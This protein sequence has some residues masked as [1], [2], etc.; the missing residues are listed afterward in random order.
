MSPAP[1]WFLDW[2]RGS[3]AL[4]DG[5]LLG[6]GC[7]YRAWWVPCLSAGAEIRR[8]WQFSHGAGVEG[9]LPEPEC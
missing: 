9:G 3:P 6:V 8:L 5:A 7:C 2:P 4:S 1:P